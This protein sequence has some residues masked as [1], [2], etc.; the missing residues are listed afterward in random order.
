MQE[1]AQN[2][3]PHGEHADRGGLSDMRQSGRHAG[4]D[5]A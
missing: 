1:N 2:L 4:G 5:Q 3:G